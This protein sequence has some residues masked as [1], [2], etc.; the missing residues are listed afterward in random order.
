MSIFNPYVMLSLIIMLAG[1]Y[2]TGH[3]YGYAERDVEM[4][5]EIA[6]KNEE[7]RAKEQEMAQALV[8]QSAKLQKVQNALS[9]KQSDLNALVDAGKL[10]LPMAEPASSCLQASASTASASGDSQE[11]GSKSERQA[12]KDIIAIAA[13]GD[14]NAVQLNACIDAYNQVRESINGN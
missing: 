11:T 2:V 1:T 5:A 10:R 3:H 4:Q 7:S 13:Q 14:S 6:K 8:D 12:I 9:K